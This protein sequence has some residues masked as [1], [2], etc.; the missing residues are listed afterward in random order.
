MTDPDQEYEAVRE[1]LGTLVGAYTHALAAERDQPG[2]DARRITELTAKQRRYWAMRR[3][4]QPSDASQILPE[5]SAQLAE[6][7]NH[8]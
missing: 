6:I 8:A 5:V 4:L 7:W 3:D 2:P 1:A